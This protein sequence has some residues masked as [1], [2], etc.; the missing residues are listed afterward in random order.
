M[1]A[2]DVPH[3][4]RTFTR[5]PGLFSFG[6]SRHSQDMHYI[7]YIYFGYFGHSAA[8]LFVHILLILRKFRIFFGH[9]PEHRCCFCQIFQT[10]GPAFNLKHHHSIGPMHGPITCTAIGPI[11][12]PLSAIGQMAVSIVMVQLRMCCMPC[13]FINYFSFLARVSCAFKVHFNCNLL[14][15]IYFW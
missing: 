12:V 14:I 15:W 8:H 4:F 10:L 3:F 11:C 2:P 9:L 1:H 6:Y 13:K 5:A 7:W